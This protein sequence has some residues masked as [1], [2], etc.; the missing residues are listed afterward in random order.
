MAAKHRNVIEGEVFTQQKVDIQPN[1]RLFDL[2][3]ESFSFNVAT[4]ADF[5]PVIPGTTLRFLQ[6]R[7]GLGGCPALWVYF[8]I[9][10]PDHCT[11][12]WVQRAEETPPLHGIFRG[13]GGT[14]KPK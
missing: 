9:D 1:A 6:T 7:D 14:L 5:F 13:N 11:L 10:G 4:W 3:I 8:T 12:R 2:V